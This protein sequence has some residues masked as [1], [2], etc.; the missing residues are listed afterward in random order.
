MIVGT[1]EGLDVHT[2]A[3][4]GRADR[5]SAGWAPATDPATLARGRDEGGTCEEAS[6]ESG[7]GERAANAFVGEG[8]T[9]TS[10][11]PAEAAVEAAAADEASSSPRTRGRRA[12]TRTTGGRSR[13][14][15]VPSEAVA[16]PR[17]S[18]S[19]RAASSDIPDRRRDRRAD[20][21]KCPRLE[22]RL[23]DSFASGVS[24]AAG[25]R[26]FAR[27]PAVPSWA[28]GFRGFRDYLCDNEEQTVRNE[29]DPETTVRD[30]GA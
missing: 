25:R 11:S 18:R 1:S 28:S 15:R 9:P 22:L 13:A 24:H 20:N 17:S 23:T 10:G 19:S 8:A 3:R 5:A 16:P 29:S 7:C 21:R 30:R 2:A 12:R 27:H 4:P 6:A 26:R 14:T